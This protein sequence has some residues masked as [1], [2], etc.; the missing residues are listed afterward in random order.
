MRIM[1]MLCT[2][3]RHAARAVL[4]LWRSPKN[5]AVI[6]SSVWFLPLPIFLLCALAATGASLQLGHF[7]PSGGW[8]G[9]RP[10]QTSEDWAT[11][12]LVAWALASGLSPVAVAQRVWAQVV[13][14][15]SQHHPPH[16]DQKEAR[17]TGS[18]LHRWQL[19]E[20]LRVSA[21][22]LRAPQ[23]RDESLH[24]SLMAEDALAR[25]KTVVHACRYDP[26]G[27]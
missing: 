21:G 17:A 25:I 27:C 19:L 22:R 4:L 7:F 20:T 23:Q 5:P 10:G 26:G 14:C 2:H 13:E 8:A 15:H 9:R 6:N 11:R 16:H 18:L 12:G 1:Y 24:G 3:T